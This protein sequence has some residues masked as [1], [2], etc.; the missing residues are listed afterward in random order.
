MAT[1]AYVSELPACQLC[2]SELVDQPPSHRKGTG[3]YAVARVDAPTN[4]GPW[5][6]MCTWHWKKYGLHYPRLGTGLGQALE[7]RK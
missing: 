3:D 4:F 7:V 6:Y 5:A 1:T 2:G